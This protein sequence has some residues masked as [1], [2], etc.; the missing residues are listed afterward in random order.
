MNN[1]ECKQILI[2]KIKIIKNKQYFLKIF[3]MKN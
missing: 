2:K 1:I 3:D